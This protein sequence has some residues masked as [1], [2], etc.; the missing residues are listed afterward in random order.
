MKAQKNP[1]RKEQL[2][3][4]DLKEVFGGGGINCPTETSYDVKGG[5]SI[6]TCDE[7]TLHTVTN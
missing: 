5:A 7:H 2:A 6:T 3:L 1:S 4:N